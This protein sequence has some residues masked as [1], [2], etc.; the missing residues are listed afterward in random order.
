MRIAR[1]ALYLAL[2]FVLRSL[3]LFVFGGGG[4]VDHHA[5]R[6][7]KQ[8]LANNIE[9]LRAINAVLMDEQ[10]A[11]ASDPERVALQARELG[12][13]REGERV[14]RL[15]GTAV[16]RVSFTVGRLVRVTPE[17]ERRDWIAKLLGLAVPPGLYVVSSVRERRR[18][19]APFHH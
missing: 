11:L 7:Q 10:Q 19:G 17:K 9:N 15:E 4:L 14:L 2:G 5:L 3:Y 6:S 8:Q 18:R 12:Y 16:S 13:F 1:L